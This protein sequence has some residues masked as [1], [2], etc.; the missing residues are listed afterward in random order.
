MTTAHPVPTSGA[1]PQMASAADSQP[2]PTVPAPTTAVRAEPGLWSKLTDNPLLTI[3]GTVAAGLL[4]ILG[5][6][7]AGLL[8][9]TLNGI[10]NRLS[11]LEDKVDA[12]FAAIDARFAEQDAK[13]AELDLKLSTQIA[14]LDRKLTALIAALNA[15]DEIEAAL[16]GRLLDSGT[17]DAEPSAPGSAPGPG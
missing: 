5:T 17:G 7:A 2:D 11:R 4:T 10:D 13:I 14:E 12:G 6:V 8:I 15:S 9:S 1:H 16:E 3:L